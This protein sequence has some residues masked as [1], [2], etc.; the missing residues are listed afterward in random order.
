MLPNLTCKQTSHT[1][2]EHESVWINDANLVTTSTF[3]ACDSVCKGWSSSSSTSHCHQHWTST[4]KLVLASSRSNLTKQILSEDP[5]PRRFNK[6]IP[7]WPPL[8]NMEDS[9]SNIFQRAIQSSKEHHS[10]QRGD[11]HSLQGEKRWSLCSSSSADP[12]LNG[13]KI[14]N[15]SICHWMTS[16]FVSQNEAKCPKIQWFQWEIQQIFT[17]IFFHLHLIGT[18]FQMLKGLWGPSFFGFPKG[19]ATNHRSST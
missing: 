10:M 11:N 5:Q 4:R 12:S 14:N 18:C 9:T 3:H 7:W 2:F 16:N 6:R 1:P 17:C 13:S 19:R 15:I 8:F